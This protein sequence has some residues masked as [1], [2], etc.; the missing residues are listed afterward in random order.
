MTAVTDRSV[1]ECMACH[2]RVTY[3]RTVCSCPNC[4]QPVSGMKSPD[5]LDAERYHEWVL[6]KRPDNVPGSEA[7]KA[8]GSIWKV[9]GRKPTGKADAE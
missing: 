5:L 6:G 9:A 3:V 1:I 8:S 2:E 4:D 7:R